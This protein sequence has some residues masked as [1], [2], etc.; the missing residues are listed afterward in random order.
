MPAFPG[1]RVDPQKVEIREIRD[2]FQIERRRSRGTYGRHGGGI[3]PHAGHCLAGIPV[4]LGQ[5]MLGKRHDLAFVNR[6]LEF[7]VRT[8]C[9]KR[10]RQHAAALQSHLPPQRHACGEIVHR[11][12]QLLLSRQQLGRCLP[13]LGRLSIAAPHTL[14]GLHRRQV[15]GSEL[16]VG[17]RCGMLPADRKP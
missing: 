3:K 1:S 6:G 9:C 7:D 8:P 2:A 15:V 10:M 12:A 4:L 11:T 5:D 17:L 13:V 16:L 14:I